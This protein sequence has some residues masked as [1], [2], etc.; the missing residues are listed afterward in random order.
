[1]GAAGGGVS[2]Y[3]GADNYRVTDCYVCGNF[4]KGQGGGIGH[5]GLSDG[6]LIA[7]N[8]IIFNQSFNQL[9]ATRPAGGGISIQG[10]TPPVGLTPGAGNVTI[11]R[12][13]IQGNLGGAGDGGGIHLLGINGEDVAENKN[14]DKKW[15][16]VNIFN[17]MIVNNVAGIA[18]G[19]I[20][21]KDAVHASII[22]NT[23]AHNE[24][25]ATAGELIN[26]VDNESTPQPGGIVA[27]EHSV[28]LA[29]V[30]QKNVT[31]VFSNPLLVNNIIWE[32]RSFYWDATQE[33]TGAGGE[34][35]AVGGLLPNTPPYW[36]L[37]VIGAAGVL[38][39]DFCVLTSLMGPDGVD[40]TDGT[41]TPAD[42]LFAA[43]YF[44]S[45]ASLL[46]I[47]ENSTPLT[48]AA[49][50][51]GG[52]FIDVRFAPLTLTGDYHIDAGSSAIDAGDGAVLGDFPELGWDF[53][54]NVRVP[55]VDIGADE[56]YAP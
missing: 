19:G 11:D 45:G 23:V 36:D 53:D 52:N 42:P 55:P 35:L 3:T 14:N 4:T 44:N 15:Y 24:S 40:Y 37:A 27:R 54:R 1:V 48:S 50:D 2:L 56:Y 39:P 33:I 29:A 8:T 22:N 26:P 34:L 7:D 17:N 20:S 47:P 43:S 18:G 13:L 5:L 9:P 28:E 41:N 32:N 49:T 12:N 6:G 10:F 25:T 38:N 31:Q 51:E 46:N 30:F 21:L 16:A